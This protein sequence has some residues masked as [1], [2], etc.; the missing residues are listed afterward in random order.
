MSLQLG[1]WHF[2]GRPV[3]P[4]DPIRRFSL[5]DL[6]AH[7]ATSS[8]QHGNIFL[9]CKASQTTWESERERQP[10]ILPSGVVAT[11]DGCLYERERLLDKLDRRD[12]AKESDL[13]LVAAAYERW[14][15]EGFAEVIGDWAVA[16][17]DP[18][19]RRL[20]LAKDHI[21][22]R[23]LYY[24]ISDSG[25]TWSTLLDPLVEN[26]GRKVALDE[27]Y[28]AGWL[29]NSAAFDR[30]PYKGI[31][32]VSPC[33]SVSIQPGRV[34]ARKYWDFNPGKRIVYKNDSEYEEHFRHVFSAAVRKRLRS[35]HPVLAELSGGMDST[36]IVC[37]ADEQIKA[38]AVNGCRLDTVSYY[39]DS[40]PSW[41]ER[42]YFTAVEQ[43]RGRVGT[44]LSARTRDVCE[45]IFQIE[46]MTLPASHGHRQELFIKL[47]ASMQSNDNRVLLSGHAGDEIM[48]GVPTPIP[49]LADL[50]AGLRLRSLA[51]QLKLWA[52]NKRSPW[53]FLLFDALRPFLPTRY[54]DFSRFAQ[55]ANWFDDSFLQQRRWPLL[56]YQQRVKILGGRPS[57][58]M[59]VDVLDGIRRQLG[60]APVL[61]NAFWEKRYPYLDRDLLEFMYAVP[62]SQV[63]RPGQ[64]RSLMRRSLRG[65]VPTL[66]LER[67]RKAFVSHGLYTALSNRYSE[68]MQLADHMRVAELGIVSAPSF[69]SAVRNGARGK[70]VNFS[71]FLRTCLL[72]S[73]L[74]GFAD[75]RL[76]LSA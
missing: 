69:E 40:E 74:R 60:C 44:H 41:D 24:S 25:V 22:V 17:W 66:V 34:L 32:S 13:A 27:E 56:A 26:L 64:R 33:H 2:D 36:G 55:Y 29:V 3:S 45:S 51:R 50:V 48:G 75:N 42:P 20:V 12:L 8:Y 16:L 73:W 47:A 49:E 61:A 28:L 67:K 30:S 52:L 38:G 19:K 9:A 35:S 76:V 68:F 18:N 5:P 59:N 37:V 54:Q 6:Y 53:F 11:W 43:Q 10:L 21:G 63:V 70:E 46:Y 65:I 57:F 4:D 15:T 1:K 62:R 14:G 58:Q 7:E 23:P 71:I 31:A 72:E 39:D